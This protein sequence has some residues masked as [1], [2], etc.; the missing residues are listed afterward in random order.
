MQTSHYKTRLR[1]HQCVLGHGS[2]FSALQCSCTRF[3]HHPE[4]AVP[5]DT[6]STT[7]RT[8]AM[9]AG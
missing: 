7:P 1:Q 3:G 8:E 4:R 5:A 6:E 2:F 9:Q